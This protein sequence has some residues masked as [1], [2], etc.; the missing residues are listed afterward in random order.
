MKYYV[1]YIWFL[2]LLMSVQPIRILDAQRANNR[3]PSPF[4]IEPL[5]QEFNRTQIDVMQQQ[6]LKEKLLKIALKNQDTVTL[7][8]NNRARKLIRKYKDRI[9]IPK[10]QQ[11]DTYQHT[12]KYDTT[13]IHPMEQSITIDTAQVKKLTPMHKKKHK[14]S[15]FGRMFQF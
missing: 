4:G 10:T 12:L 11:I 8:I 3:L 1:I 2:A 13:K 9:E 14:L 5:T 15:L 7:L 6:Y